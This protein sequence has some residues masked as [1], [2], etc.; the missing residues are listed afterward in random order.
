MS[1]TLL[2]LIVAILL[3]WVAW[4]IGVLIAPRILASFLAYW[5]PTKPS[6]PPSPDSWRAAKN[7]TPSASTDKTPP[8]AQRP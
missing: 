4:Q 3:V 5:R 2:E 1:P 8:H 6:A 7:V